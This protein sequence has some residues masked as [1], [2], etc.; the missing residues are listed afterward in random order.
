MTE[1]EKL[2]AYL[3]IKQG[4]QTMQLYP[5]GIMLPGMGMNFTTFMREVGGLSTGRVAQGNFDRLRPSTLGKVLKNAQEWALGRI[6]AQGW[7]E[8]EGREM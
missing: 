7:P 3:Q 2:C 6:K 1:A 5:L 8:E 4:V